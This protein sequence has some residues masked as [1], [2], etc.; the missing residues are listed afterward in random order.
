VPCLSLKCLLIIVAVE[1]PE[2][3]SQWMGCLTVELDFEV[4][5]GSRSLFK[6]F[7]EVEVQLPI[8]TTLS[9]LERQTLAVR[10]PPGSIVNVATWVLRCRSKEGC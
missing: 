10:K 6:I 9:L 2:Y 4:R 8:P 1:L 5:W 3:R 7:V